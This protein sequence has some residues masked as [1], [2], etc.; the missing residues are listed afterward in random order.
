MNRFQPGVALLLSLLWEVRW[1]ERGSARL[2]RLRQRRGGWFPP[3][4]AAGGDWGWSAISRD[5]EPRGRRGNSL[6]QPGWVVV[7]QY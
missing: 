1:G 5:L 2:R 7:L 6:T 3:E 4:R